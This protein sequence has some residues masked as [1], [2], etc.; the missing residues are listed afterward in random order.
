MNEKWDYKVVR[1]PIASTNMEEELKNL[2]QDGW[3]LV[4]SIATQTL[5][6][7]IVTLKRKL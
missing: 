6:L 4:S 5:S 2:G 1:I 3:E 7:C